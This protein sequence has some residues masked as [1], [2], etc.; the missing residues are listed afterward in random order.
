M[1][2]SNDSEEEPF[3]GDDI[4]LIKKS[5]NYSQ[6]EKH[7]M[8]LKREL[9]FL[10]GISIVVGIVIGAGIFATPSVILKHSGSVGV[11]FL[12]WLACGILS[13]LT[14]LCYIE[15]GCMIGKSGSEYAYLREAFGST[16]SY[17]WFF[18][19]AF[20]LKPASNSMV[21][22]VMGHYI[23]EAFYPE[24]SYA[25]RESHAKILALLALAIIGAINSLSVRLSANVTVVFTGAK[26][27]G[28][29]IIS[30]VGIIRLFQGHT[31]AF[32]HA[33][34]GR[35]VDFT[36]IGYSF[37]GGLFAFD[38]WHNINMALEELKNPRK[39]LRLCLICG[40]FLI[41]TCYL[42]VNVGYLTVMTPGEMI[43]SSAVAANVSNRLFGAVKWIIPII[44]ACSCFGSMNGG[45]FATSRL[46]YVA[47]RSKEMPIVCAM[48]H[49]KWRTPIPAV[50]INTIL[51]MAMLAPKTSNFASLLKYN[52]FLSWLFYGVTIFA[53]LWLRY[54]KASMKRPYKVFIG[55]PILV[56]VVCLYLF[57]SAVARHVLQSCIALLIV[58]CSVPIHLVFVRYK[59]A[60]KWMERM[61]ESGSYSLQ[62]LLDLS[63]PDVQDST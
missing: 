50:L 47:A 12:I 6:D 26:L 61:I 40:L 31:F 44:V 4:A 60:P 45:A 15:L 30:L 38:G 17:V 20:I 53:L 35:N 62:L 23:I 21:S 42:T 10:H 57:V 25:D 14:A 13:I 28:V 32:Q 59:L 43:A 51:S 52:G 54:T 11:S 8:R 2:D 24:C 29:I 19:M 22:M 63:L 33:F 49:R 34:S 3:V 1:S 36:D 27:V 5:S 16:A 41:T 7:S 56:L 58:L 37:Y 46:F 39:N 55:I 18:A 9:N 48:I